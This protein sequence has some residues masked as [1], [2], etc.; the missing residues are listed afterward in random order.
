MKLRFLPQ[1]AF[2]EA[3]NPELQE[4]Q[5][6]E[7]D[8]APEIEDSEP[9]DSDDDESCPSDINQLR[10]ET[11]YQE[12]P[13]NE[14]NKNL[15]GKKTLPEPTVRLSREDYADPLALHLAMYGSKFYELVLEATNA[16]AEKLK[17]NDIMFQR[18]YPFTLA[19]I[20]EFFGILLIMSCEK[21]R[22][23]DDIR[24]FLGKW[25]KNPQFLGLQDYDLMPTCKFQFLYYCLDIGA[26]VKVTNQNNPNFQIL[27]MAE[28]FGP[29]S[30]FF[31]ERSQNLKTPDRNIPL[32]V[33]EC[34]RGSYSKSN[35]IKNF[36]PNKPRKYGDKFFLLVDG[37]RFCFKII[38][39]L[40]KQFNTF[41]GLDDLVS[42]MIPL[43]FRNLGFTLIGDNYFF[44][45]NSLL[46][47]Q[48]ENTSVVCTMRR[49][50]LTKAIPKAE[51]DQIAKKV[52][53]NNFQ[54]K[55]LIKE[56]KMPKKLFLQI[57]VYSDKSHVKPVIFAITDPHLIQ[58]GGAENQ[59]ISKRLREKTTC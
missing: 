38:M 3:E 27:D 31:N 39:Q 57:Q 54:R 51:L 17:S 5:N 34:L 32:V 26:D 35:P 36:M 4:N 21:N 43:R 41:E 48:A 18:Y 19:D 8:E 14:R 52:S 9:E 45:L 7:P 24:R 25:R 42:Q 12:H 53:K 15:G 55:I 22:E 50:R 2:E 28:K 47:L 56:A 20:H 10:F 30:H 58:S 29:I 49:N 33:D 1:V 46:K 13:E 16:K 6:L 37:D 40:P 11:V 44:T 59:N 23:N